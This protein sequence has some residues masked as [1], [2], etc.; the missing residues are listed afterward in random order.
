MYR[1]VGMALQP[2][3]E[4]LRIQLENMQAQIS[5]PTQFRVSIF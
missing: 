1:K 2:E 5:I 3:E 4:H